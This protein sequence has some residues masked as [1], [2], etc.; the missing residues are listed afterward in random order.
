MRDS[1][2]EQVKAMVDELHQVIAKASGI[3]LEIVEHPPISIKVR[4]FKMPFRTNHFNLNQKVWV[5]KTTGSLAARVVGRYRGRFRYTAAWVNWDKKGRTC[6]D[7]K[8]ISVSAEFAIR[9]QLEV[10]RD[11]KEELKCTIH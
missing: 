5:M 3:P 10:C 7:F 6:P 4:M 9:R 8:E 1:L 11:Y 2:K